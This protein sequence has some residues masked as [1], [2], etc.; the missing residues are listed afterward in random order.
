MV[1]AHR[2]PATHKL[3][4]EFASESRLVALFMSEHETG[5]EMTYDILSFGEPLM[6]LTRVDEAYVPGF[7]GDTSNTAIAAA[8]Q[9]AR[10]AYVSAL[11]ADAFGAGIRA[12]WKREGVDDRFVLTDEAAPTGLYIITPSPGGR[13]FAYY[14]ANSAAS[15]YRP[16]PFPSDAIAKSQI[17]HLS[18]I[19]QAIGEVRVMRGFGLSKRPARL[20]A[21]LPTTR[22]SG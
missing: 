14:R 15:R 4:I 2:D 8:R 5:R 22:T 16:E 3:P 6:E 21:R 10:V 20:G 18:G 7:G 13:D 1:A 12:L 11:G 9:G 17:V 19:S